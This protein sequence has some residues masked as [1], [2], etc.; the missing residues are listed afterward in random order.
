MSLRHNA[1]QK[2]GAEF[3]RIGRAGLI[4]HEQIIAEEP[5]GSEKSGQALDKKISCGRLTGQ[6][7]IIKRIFLF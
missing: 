1:F 7:K 5:A 3:R 6:E 4:R 2:P